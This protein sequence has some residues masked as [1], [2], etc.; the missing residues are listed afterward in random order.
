MRPHLEYACAMLDPHT[1]RD[2]NRFRILLLE[3]VLSSTLVHTKICLLPMANLPALKASRMLLKLCT[4]YK[5]YNYG[6]FGGVDSATW[7]SQ[8]YHL[9][10]TMQCAPAL[11]L[12]F[13]VSYTS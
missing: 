4:F 6:V 8:L 12:F 5:V 11:A 13:Q 1:K 7:H 2:I 10:L 3:S 9:Y